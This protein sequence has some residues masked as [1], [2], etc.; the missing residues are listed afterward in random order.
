[1]GKFSWF[2]CI[3]MLG[4]FKWLG[5][6]GWLELA[7]PTTWACLFKV[8]LGVLSKTLSHMW[9]KLNLSI[10][11]FKVG[12]LALINIDSLIFLAKGCPF[13][14]IIWKFCWVVGRPVL[15]LWWCMGE[16]SFRHQML[17]LPRQVTPLH[18]WAVLVPSQEGMQAMQALSPRQGLLGLPGIL[19][20]RGENTLEDPKLKG[21]INLSSKPLT[22]AQRSVLAKGPNFLV[23]P[24]H[25][26]NLEYIT[27]I[28]SVCSKLGQ[29]E[30]RAHINRVLRS[31]YPSNL[32]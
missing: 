9:G 3:G 10:F 20:P 24:K 7:C 11:L 8:R 15:L 25:T 29:Q 21:V 27:A 30:L 32:I 14:P 16:G 6:L 13:L 5:M 26:P 4:W 31:S 28:E 12:L 22:Q 18:W 17:V 19:P 2:K 23:T 1:M